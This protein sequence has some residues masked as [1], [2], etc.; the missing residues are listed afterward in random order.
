MD[1]MPTDS[2]FAVFIFAFVVSFGAVISPGPVSA[3]IVTEA[4][5]QGWRVG[6]LVAFGHTL[7][8][9]LMVLLITFGLSVWMV[10][11]I[12]HTG[13]ALGG[14]L[15]L[16]GIGISYI[17]AAWR[18]RIGLPQAETR[19]PT[20]SPFSLFIL[21]IVATISNPFWYTWWVTV[22]AGYLFQA[23]ALGYAAIGAFYLGHTLADFSWDTTLALATSAGRRWLTN[24]RYR[25]LIFITGGFMLYLGVLFFYSALT[26]RN[27]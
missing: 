22:A 21:G 16:F 1:W 4:P 15:L 9:L 12:V 19:T 3:M 26:G 27:T 8:E 13:I 17:I 7:L 18:G 10:T 14:G 23:Q 20:R 6:P 24:A 11:P 5:R 2:L 25:A